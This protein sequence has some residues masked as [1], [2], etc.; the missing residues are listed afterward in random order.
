MLFRCCSL[1]RLKEKRERREARVGNEMCS[2]SRKLAPTS[3]W[4]VRSNDVSV[5]DNNNND[6]Q[7]KKD[8]MTKQMTKF[9]FSFR[10]HFK[11]ITHLSRTSLFSFSRSFLSEFVFY[12]V[13]CSFLNFQS[14]STLFCSHNT[15]TTLNA[16]FC[17]YL[18]FLMV[19]Q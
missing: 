2:S 15:R 3:L 8:A 9:K 12:A 13:L 11:C 5:D 17:M 16:L 19:I 14:Q 1:C 4:T 7:N 18:L 6:T 10:N